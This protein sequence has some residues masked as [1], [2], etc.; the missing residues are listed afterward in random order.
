MLHRRKRLAAL[1]VSYSLQSVWCLPDV[2]PIW[3]KDWLSEMPFQWNKNQ[4]LLLEKL[5]DKY[6]NSKSYEDKNLIKQRFSVRPEDFFEKWRDTKNCCAG[7]EACRI[8][9]DFGKD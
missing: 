8:L 3:W 1:E 2:I 9:S 7:G 4:K 6:E 5:L